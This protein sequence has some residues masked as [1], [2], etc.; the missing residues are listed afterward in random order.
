[1][2]VINKR[3]DSDN[4]QIIINAHQ[5]TADV[6]SRNSQ[7]NDA[8]GFA[9]NAT[10]AVNPSLIESREP[11]KPWQDRL[12][13]ED[14]WTPTGSTTVMYT[15]IHYTSD[16]SLMG[17]GTGLNIAKS[18][19]VPSSIQYNSRYFEGYLQ[20][21]IADID[22]LAAAQS[23]GDI[24]A[25]VSVVRQKMEAVER[26][27][28]KLQNDI[29]SKG[30]PREGLVGILNHPDVPRLSLGRALGPAN[31]P[32]D[33]LADL[34]QI[35]R[36][37]AIV[38]ATTEMP[39]MVVLPTS[40]FYDLSGQIFSQGGESSVLRRYLQ[41]S[42]SVKNADVAPEL[43]IEEN[44]QGNYIFMYS[45]DPMKICRVVPKNMSFMPPQQQG[46]GYLVYAHGQISGV[47]IKYPFS[48]VLADFEPA[49]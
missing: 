48:C 5:R 26:G 30:K 23:E 47:H 19:A 9:P 4:Q 43:G 14:P 44:G 20:Y 7:R 27:W 36:A 15:R 29:F 40:T 17:D 21:S 34:N 35:E 16:W 12:I 24:A 42:P 39:D 38:S 11:A 45:R 49:T 31:S 33:N 13:P 1:M 22:R 28:R 10:R 46:N 8:Y 3:T 2:H 37:I 32:E 6:I 18:D 25:E 41:N